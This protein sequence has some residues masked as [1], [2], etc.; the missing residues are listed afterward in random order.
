MQWHTH[1]GII[2]N[3]L[4]DRIDFILPELSAAIIVKWNFHVDDFAKGGYDMILGRYILTA[5]VFI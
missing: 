4:K 5:L 1:S 2:T 3:N